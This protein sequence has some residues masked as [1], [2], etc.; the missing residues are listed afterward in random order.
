MEGDRFISGDQVDRKLFVACLIHDT[1]Q[2]GERFLKR[3]QQAL[4][5][6]AP[7]V[8]SEQQKVQRRKYMLESSHYLTVDTPAANFRVHNAIANALELYCNLKRKWYLGEKVLFELMKEQDPEAY[9]I[10]SDAMKPESSRQHKSN[11]F[12]FIGKIP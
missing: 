4:A 8:L 2:I 9:R 5:E 7:E 12:Q 3:T 10:F 6:P 11:L 1:D